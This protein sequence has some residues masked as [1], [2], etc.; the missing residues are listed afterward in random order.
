MGMR[1]ER[2][3][4]EESKTVGKKCGKRGGNMRKK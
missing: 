3:G 4:I 2:N 1:A